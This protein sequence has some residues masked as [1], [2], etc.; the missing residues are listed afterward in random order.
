M[1]ISHGPN[2][3]DTNNQVTL[4]IVS[5]LCQALAIEKL[6]YCH[7]KSNEAI[8]R[9]ACGDNDLDLL[10]SRADAQ[11][12]TEILYRLGF[13]EVQSHQ[14]KRL[15]GILS[16]YGYEPE[17]NKLIHVHMHYQ[18]ILGNDL[19]K[20]YHIPLEQPYLDSAT[21]TEL[22]R[23]P[24]PEF[25]LVIFVLRMVLKHITW[26]SILM[27]H[28]SLS[29]SEHREFDYL[30]TP[31]NLGKAGKVLEKHLPYIDRPLFDTCLQSLQ[32]HCALMQRIQTG[33]KLQKALAA[34]ARK[35]QTVDIILKF[36][37]RIWQPFQWRILRQRPKRRMANGGMLIAIVGGDGAGKTTAVD[38][39]SGWLSKNFEILKLHMGK[40]AW[41][42]TTVLIRGFLKIGTIIGLYSFDEEPGNGRKLPVYPRLIR[43][44][45]TARDRYLTY[46]KGRRFASNGGLAISDRYSI[47]DFLKMDAPQCEKLAKDFDISNWFLHWLI[48]I[49]NAYYQKIMLPDL[50]IVLRLNPEIAVQRKKGDEDELFVL[51][52]STLVWELDWSKMPAHVVDANK[53]KEEVFSEIKML[54]WSHL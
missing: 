54:L 33:N 13:R 6:N 14:N 45:C 47:S 26:D 12:F 2:S 43:A 48:R 27:R 39:I 49:E 53:P 30:A 28:G 46:L 7:W 15:P 51:P 24:A 31:E 41:S 10:V 19:T 22:F 8:S 25:E 4:N 50:L 32:P 20:N 36:F 5:E 42:W 23:I 11:R 40:P 3:N 52:R 16:Y 37:R 34:C 18:L 21:Q 38:E 1:N 35:P 44:V 29:P 9:S 17:A